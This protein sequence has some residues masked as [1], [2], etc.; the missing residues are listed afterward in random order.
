M[1]EKQLAEI[2]KRANLP[3]GEGFTIYKRD[4]NAL[5]S[6]LRE[7]RAFTIRALE[8]AHDPKKILTFTFA[9]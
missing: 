6:A 8:L 3:L 4:V 7:A 9:D 2:E 5:C 1:N